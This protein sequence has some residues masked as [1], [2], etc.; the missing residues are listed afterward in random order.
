[1]SLDTESTPVTADRSTCE[2]VSGPLSRVLTLL[3]KRWTGMVLGTLIAGPVYFIDL[4][5]GIPGISDRLLTERLLELAE[6]GLVTRTVVDLPPVR[7]R[8]EL[9]E[10]G[11]ALGPAMRALE[12]WAAANFAGADRPPCE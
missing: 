9:S 1:M 12:A 7:V 11:Q 5:R 6:L 4:R 2:S 3:G 10:K 8:Y